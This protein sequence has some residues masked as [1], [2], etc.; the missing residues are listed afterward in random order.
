ML[1]LLKTNSF[2]LTPWGQPSCA[3]SIA[4]IFFIFSSSVSFTQNGIIKG[5]VKDGETALQAATISI[6]HKSALTNSDGGF[7]ITIAAG[8]F[9][10]TITHVGYK[11]IEQTII[12][13]SGET[14]SFN[15]G[16]IKD[17]QLG[18]VV[19][20]GSRSVTPR[21]N[22][23][24]AVPVDGISINELK[25]TGQPSLIQMLNFVAPSFNTSRQHQT[26]PVTIRG[27]SPDHLLILLNGTRYHTD[28]GIN[29]GAIRGTLG[30]GSVSN[31]LNSIPFSAIEKIE[32]LR[33]GASAQYGSDA[34]AGVMN[35]EL[36]KTTGKTFINLHLGQQYKGDGE[37]VVFGINRGISLRKKGFLNFSTDFRYRQPTHR[38]GEYR[39]TVYKSY[40]MFPITRG[41]SLKIKAA[42]DSIISA[43]GFSRKTPVSNDGSIELYSFGFLVNGSYQI[44]SNVETFWTGSA[45][46]RHPHVRGMYRFPKASNQVNTVLYPDGFKPDITGNSWDLSGIF[47]VKGTTSNGWNWDLKSVYGEQS[48]TSYIKNTNNASIVPWT[49]DAQTLF[50]TGSSV[51]RQQTNSVTFAKDFAKEISRVK[52]F[53]VG[54]GA[55][56]R[57]ENYRTKAGEESS[58]RSYDTSRRTQPGSQPTPGRSQVDVVNESRSIAALYIDL[59]SDMTDHFLIAIA[60]RYEHYNSFGNNLA[61]K[62]A[63]RYKFSAPLSI[64]GSVSNGYHAPALQ[65]IYYTTTGSASRNMGGVIV[66]VRIG[67]F[68]NNSVITKAFG[69]KP[70][71]PEKAVNISAGFTSI[72][73]PHINITVDAYRIQI[74]DRIVLSGMFDKKTNPE[75]SKILE[76][77]PDVDL[78]QF[79]TNA[80]NTKTTGIDIVLNGSWKIRKSN[81]GLMLAAN[82]TSTKVFGPI[83]TTDKLTA[84]TLNTN[85]LFNRE[86][87]EKIENGQP[88]SKIILSANYKKGKTGFLIRG[89]RFGKTSAVFSSE[90]KSR[91]EFFSAK[92]LT[93]FSINYSPKT[94]LTITA[95]ANNIF[96]EY[97]DK[98]KNYLNT[99]EG[100]LVYGN[101]AMPFGYNGGYVFLSIAFNW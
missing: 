42:D 51:F 43:R 74:K 8:T 67:T 80:I 40:P 11:K 20:L 26:D 70:L 50:N 91:D 1:G 68:S 64:R 21:S 93:D 16:M 63:M 46:A 33:D 24:T 44:T 89:T 7:Y 90:D 3:R 78:V 66:P 41:D 95:G 62:L 2:Y 14:K 71:Q 69:V 92:I 76:N 72:I 28:A 54:F 53:N 58:W 85:I 35:I 87:R 13:N 99:N 34:I 81:V 29:S 49:A 52:T 4:L 60:S 75:V 27:L 39:G 25:Q 30:K 45:N 15:F 65:Q 17:G 9:T 23:N 47:G 31:D 61:G 98:L 82:L 19:L 101:E 100:I 32:I 79:V 94:W 56:Y 88:G 37:S 36:K 73:S 22:L 97:P 55:E 83:Q 48:N 18:E 86:E 57:L 6:E 12:L 96:D 77:Y 10:L 59:E 38:G 84:D 5:T